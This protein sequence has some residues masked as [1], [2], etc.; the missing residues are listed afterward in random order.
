LYLPAFDERVYCSVSSEGGIGIEQSNWEADWYLGPPC[1]E[2]DF[3]FF[4]R[5]I[6]AM[7][8]PR[9]FLLIDGNA[10]DGD[11]S[12]TYIAAAIPIYCLYGNPPYLG[13]CNHKKGHA[14][15]PEAEKK[16]YEWLDAFLK[17]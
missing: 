7:I 13:F 4:H 15:P 2:K 8:A 5:E 17:P 3:L 11:T 1:K 9:P 6:L 14:V 10:S 16:T 12:W